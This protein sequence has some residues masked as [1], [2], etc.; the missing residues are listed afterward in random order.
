LFFLV[1]CALKSTSVIHLTI[2]KEI[3]EKYLKSLPFL[4][5]NIEV[6]K[7]YHNDLLD[8]HVES[9]RICEPI[10][11]EEDYLD[12]ANLQNA[13]LDVYIFQLNDEQVFEEVDDQEDLVTSHQWILP[14]RELHPLWDT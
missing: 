4:L 9:I 12:H 10:R 7:P 6:S 3:L 13:E 8:E 14:S 1:E 11:S 2:L 5:Y